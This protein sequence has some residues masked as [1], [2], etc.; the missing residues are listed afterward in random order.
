MYHDNCTLIKAITGLNS[1]TIN[2][3]LYESTCQAAPSRCAPDFESQ[4]RSRGRTLS[5]RTQTRL[6]NR[7]HFAQSHLGY[8]GY[9]K[10]LA[11]YGTFS[12]LIYFS[13]TFNCFLLAEALTCN[14]CKYNLHPPYGTLVFHFQMQSS[15]NN[16]CGITQFEFC[17]WG[18]YYIML[19]NWPS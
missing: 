15:W 18:L 13:I 2:C 7:C 12:A 9:I 3:Y 5:D 10:R 6:I 17:C 19:S 1:H 8:A 11:Q 14:A 4:E 16:D